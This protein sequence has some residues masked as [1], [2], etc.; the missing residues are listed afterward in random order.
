MVAK[1]SIPS[2]V[3]LNS[4]TGTVGKVPW[5]DTGQAIRFVMA[6]PVTRPWI[7][8]LH[9]RRLLKFLLAIRHLRLEPRQNRAVHLADA[10]LAQ[11]QRRPD[12]LH[13]HFLKVV[14]DD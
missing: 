3:R 11:I 7:K 5:R 1:P 14:E 2:R 12:L 13:G 8:A 10:R 9:R 6:A 4:R